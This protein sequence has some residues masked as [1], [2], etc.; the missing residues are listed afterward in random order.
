MGI[1]VWDPRGTACG[2][3]SCIYEETDAASLLDDGVPTGDGG[4]GPSIKEGEQAYWF[5]QRAGRIG[6]P[7][8][9]STSLGSLKVACTG[10]E[11]G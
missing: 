2:L 4:Q 8:G 9:T 7:R 10:G 11:S 5:L 3:D 1:R 6:Y